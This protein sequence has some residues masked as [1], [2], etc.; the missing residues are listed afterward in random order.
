[1]SIDSNSFN[2]RNHQRIAGTALFDASMFDMW[3]SS[4]D[5]LSQGV[6]QFKLELTDGGS[7]A[8]PRNGLI[9]YRIYRVRK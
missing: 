2:T 7:Q 9:N 5:P 4:P 6:F 1:V 8:R 3:N